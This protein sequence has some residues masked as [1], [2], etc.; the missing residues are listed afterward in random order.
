MGLSFKKGS[1]DVRLSP[2]RDIIQKLLDHG[3]SHIVAYDP[4]AN[5]TFARE[6]NFPIQYA[7]SLN[8]LM[9]RSNALLLLTAWDEFKDNAEVIKQKKLFDFRYAL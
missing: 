5:K 9:E 7:D 2:T 3:F 6:Y 8:E 1:D 4:L